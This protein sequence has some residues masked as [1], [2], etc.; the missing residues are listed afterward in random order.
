MMD[1]IQFIQHQGRRILYLNLVDAVPA[2]ILQ[3]VSETIPLVA[4]QPQKSLY[5]I[6]DVRNMRF[7]S[8]STEALKRLAKH[9]GPYV[10]AG[11][12]VGVSGLRK[13]IYTAVMKFS[14]RN[15]AVFD[16]VDQAKAWLLTQ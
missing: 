6:I 11:T 10:I 8:D 13:I 2:D 7:D 3:L 16:T 5:T 15:L 1:R 14:G 4:S 12:V 9:N